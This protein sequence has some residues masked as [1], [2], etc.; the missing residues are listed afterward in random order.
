[1]CAAYAGSGFQEIKLTVFPGF[2]KLG[3]AGAIFESE[4]LQQLGMYILKGLMVFV[5]GIQAN[6]LKHASSVGYIKWGVQVPGKQTENHLSFIHEGIGMIHISRFVLLDQVF[7]SFVTQCLYGGPDLF[8][9]M[10][11]FYAYRAGFCPGFDY[12]GTGN[13]MQVVIN[14]LIIEERGK[15]RNGDMGLGCFGSHGELV[16]KIARRCLS[17]TGNAKIF[18][19]GSSL[20]DIEIVQCDYPIHRLVAQHISQTFNDILDIFGSID[21][22]FEIKKIIYGF[23]G[24]FFVGQTAFG[25]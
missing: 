12:P 19:D 23:S 8:N 11:F 7:M 22:T 21:L 17:H 15:G 24:P 6:G 16:A 25:Q 13:G 14:F 18:A 1:M 4:R 9:G 20:F 5:M 2:D 10:D 3:M